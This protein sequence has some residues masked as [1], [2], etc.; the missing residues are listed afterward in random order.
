MP[1]PSRVAPAGMRWGGEAIA[2][3]AIVPLLGHWG[4]VPRK[5]RQRGDTAVAQESPWPSDKR[6]TIRA[7]VKVAVATV[8]IGGTFGAL[9]AVYR[10]SVPRPTPAPPPP[11]PP[12]LH[13]THA[14][15]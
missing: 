1:S 15:I 5:L 2:R 3:T 13:A 14:A 9:W 7:A 12:A 11:R 6:V 8:F 4:V 10:P